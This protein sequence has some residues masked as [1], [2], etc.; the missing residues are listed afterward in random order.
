MSKPF[1]TIAAV[2]I[3]LCVV[4]AAAAYSFAVYRYPVEGWG[5]F[6]PMSQAEG[7]AEAAVKA[8]FLSDSDP[9]G[10]RYEALFRYFAAGAVAHV[11]PGGARIH[12]TGAG[13]I[14]GYRL[15]GLEGFARISPL[16]AAWVA[17]GRGDIAIDGR[18][19]DLAAF[20]RRGILAGTDA[21]SESYWGKIRDNDLRILE[22]ADIA[23][24]V[25]MTR[26]QIWNELTDDHKRQVADWLL[27]VNDATTG[28]NN[29]L[30]AAVTVTSVMRSLGWPVAFDETRPYERF[31]RHYLGAGWFYDQPGQVDYYN[32]WGI[33]YELFWI[34]LINDQFDRDFIRQTI[35]DSA[36]LTSH[37]LG[38][39]GFPI[40]G[41]SICYRTAVP[42]PLIAQAQ[43]TADP[44][45]ADPSDAGLARR[46][47]DAIWRY[48]VA[49]GS[50]RDG[51]LT[52]GY[53]GTDLRLVDNYSGPG[54]CHWGLRSLVLAFRFPG[55]SDFWNAPEVPLPVEVADYRLEVEQLG[56]IVEGRKAD[57]T[58]TIEIP[59]NESNDIAI[60]DYDWRR[61]LYEVVLRRP[62]RPHNHSVKYDRRVY[63]S[64]KPF[65]ED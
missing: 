64:A 30:L 29:W 28:D 43:L 44:S 45:D 65:W 9:V 16:L 27:Q 5:R 4:A 1:L 37:L 17:S 41:R 59:K 26:N 11:S 10:T 56:W 12:Y 40:L 55:D 50:L 3:S 15:S 47:T 52:Q 54:S 20:L 53:F 58:I 24:A 46:A 23:R 21:G 48:F 61:R 13:S 42:V 60:K 7:P 8:A 51:A 49:R 31:K 18:R 32:N 57:G 35:K 14:N 25:W 62:N 19:V 38:P 22:A 36:G 63:S 33:A 34:T 6:V 2:C 39:Q